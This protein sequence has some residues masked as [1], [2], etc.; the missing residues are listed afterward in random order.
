MKPLRALFV[1]VC[2]LGLTGTVAITVDGMSS[3]SAAPALVWAAILATVAAAPCLLHRRAW[4][5][6]LLL[7]PLGALLLLSVQL[8]APH[9]VEGAR[10]HLAHYGTQFGEGIDTWATHRFPV[11]LLAVPGLKALVSLVVYGVAWLAAVAAFGLRRPVLALVML[12][13]PLGFGLTVDGRPRTLGVPLAFLLFGAGLLLA[14]RALARRSWSANA[15]AMGLGAAVAVAVAA[16]W[17]VDATSLGEQPPWRDWRT[18]RI[19][20]RGDT[21]FGFDS[22]EGY[23][24]LLDPQNDKEVMRV[25]SPVASYWRANALDVFDGTAWRSEGSK[26]SRLEIDQEAREYTY[27]VP[28][29]DLAPQGTLVRQSF[30][31]GEMRSAYFFVGGAPRTLIKEDETPVLATGNASLGLSRSIG[32]DVAY[33]A[34]VVVPRVAPADLVDLGRY[35]PQHVRRYASLPFPTPAE[36]AATALESDWRTAM[37]AL[38]HHREWLGLYELNERIVGDATDPYEVA[39][40]IERYLRANYLYSLAPPSPWQSSPY[41]QFL[42]ETKLGFCQHFAGAMA[43][44]LRF[45]GVP[46]RVAVGFTTGDE[47]D[48]DLYVVSRNDAHAWVEVYFPRVGWVQFEPTPGQRAIAGG[49]SSTSQGFRDPFVAVARGGGG[50]TTPGR[51]TPRGFLEAPSEGVAAIPAASEPPLLAGE[52]LPWAIPAAAAVVLAGWPLA[53]AAWRRRRLRRG[54]AMQR[55]AAEFALIDAEL[56]DFGVVVPRSY[57]LDETAALLHERLG[58]D[59]ASVAERVQAVAF[60][61]RAATGDDVAAVAALRRDVRRALREHFG[62]RRAL[63]AFYGLRRAPS[64]ERRERTEHEA[65]RP[66]VSPRRL[67]YLGRAGGR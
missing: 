52:R 61:G 51:E 55:L 57:T 5:A 24:G 3:P 18:W 39:L 34:S 35:Y 64:A 60:G 32:P 58:V 16:V 25:T 41:A 15:T 48:D 63:L 12:L 46:A 54:D 67:P 62:R 49:A 45:N 43:V 28:P 6:A 37:T 26:K 9:D 7:L 14:T 59:A 2:V 56:K 65:R 50:V 20:L 27:V 30:K 23:A 36:S 44:L 40:R 22:M 29:V 42:L 66:P 1:F 47:V 8:P 33:S 4:P 53:R 19:D 21:R 17:L 38:P 13:V 31:I 10:A 11:D